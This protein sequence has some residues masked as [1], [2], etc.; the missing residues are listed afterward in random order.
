VGIAGRPS[1]GTAKKYLCATQQWSRGMRDGGLR[2]RG[3][4]GLDS[5]LPALL[6]PGVERRPRRL[7]RP[8]A[9]RASRP[10]ARVPRAIQREAACRPKSSPWLSAGA[11]P[12]GA[13]SAPSSSGSR[14]RAAAPSTCSAAGTAPAGRLLAHRVIRAIRQPSGSAAT[15]GRGGEAVRAL[16]EASDGRGSRPAGAPWRRI[17]RLG[18]SSSV[19]SAMPHGPDR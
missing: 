14:A 19:V 4:A 1:P 11:F 13:W 10:Y 2:P 9:G 5:Y 17:L 12:S 16:R 6:W 15:P 3:D 8:V 18:E 7:L